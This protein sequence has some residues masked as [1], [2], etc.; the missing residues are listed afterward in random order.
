M[1]PTGKSPDILNRQRAVPVRVGRLR[2]F[3]RRLAATARVQ[4]ESFSVVLVSDRRIRELNRRYRQRSAATDVLSFPLGENGFLGDVVISAETA[5]RQAR[6]LGHGLDAEL[7]LLLLHGVL[8][9]MGHDHETDSGEMNRRERGLRR[10]L[11]LE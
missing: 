8:H 9:L 11:G 3:A 6:R 5:R 1:D 10:R 7:R 4:P 2:E